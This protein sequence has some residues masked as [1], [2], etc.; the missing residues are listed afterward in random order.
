LPPEEL[1]ALEAR[2]QVVFRYSAPKADKSSGAGESYSPNG[3][4]NGIAGVTNERGNVLGLMPHPERATLK[5]LI[6]GTDG[7][8]FWHSIGESFGVWGDK[9]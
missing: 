1:A 3:S 4:L 8:I 9:K 5:N 7:R 6:R 2:G